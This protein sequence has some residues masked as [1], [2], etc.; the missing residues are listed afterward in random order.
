MK[1]DK[2]EEQINKINKLI[3][4]WFKSKEMQNLMKLS[5]TL[6]N[7]L[8]TNSNQF[9]KITHQFSELSKH[10]NSY[11]PY[12]LGSIL[13]NIPNP[14]HLNNLSH[15]FRYLNNPLIQQLK[16]INISLSENILHCIDILLKEGW[17]IDEDM[18]IQDLR[19]IARTFE[20]GDIKLAEKTLL[21]YLK[22]N[23]KKIREDITSTFKDRKIPIEQALDAHCN[24]LYCLSIPVFL[25][26][27]D[28]ISKEITG[29]GF[30]DKKNGEPKT[31]QIYD[32]CLDSQVIKKAYLSP[33]AK[34]TSYNISEKERC[35]NFLGLNR[36]MVLHGESFDYGTEVNSYKSLS[37][38]LYL[39]KI[40]FSY[41]QDN[42]Y[43]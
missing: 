7:S 3:P 40:V 33:L 25:A 18:P 27:V 26:Q 16:Q 19:K 5:S 36:H 20:K 22:N 43:E 17:Y 10:Y 13:N 9:Q 30:F 11:K 28:G 34:V 14:S 4:P 38:L 21:E 35:D 29:Y 37:L 41:C 12:P 15:Y 1:Y 32:N 2:L 42:K 39:T 8:N 6:N 23:I 31:K 24:G